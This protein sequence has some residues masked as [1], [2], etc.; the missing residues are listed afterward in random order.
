MRWFVGTSLRFRHLVVFLAVVLVLFGMAEVP[1]MPVDAFP[2]FAPP[3]VEVQSDGPGMSTVE[4]EELLTIPLEQAFAGTPGL[5]VMRS[6]SVP[7]T[8]DIRMIFKLGTDPLLARQVVEERLAPF[9]AAGD[10]KSTRLN[11]S[12]VKIS[13]AVFC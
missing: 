10:R 3:I 2:E 8:A 6:K 13:Y 12:H 4:V 7:G 5:D 9:A 11:S 1:H